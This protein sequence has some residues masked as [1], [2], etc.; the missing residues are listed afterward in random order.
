MD[1]LSE[2]S[3][4]TPDENGEVLELISARGKKIIGPKL[5]K[6]LVICANHLEALSKVSAFQMPQCRVPFPANT[7][8]SPRAASYSCCF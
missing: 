4:G 6:S 7:P 2:L 5:Y 1:L 8:K 3:L